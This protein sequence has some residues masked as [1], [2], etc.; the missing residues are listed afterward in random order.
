M[1]L[2]RAT[3]I[4]FLLVSLGGSCRSGTPDSE[5]PAVAP[6]RA[7]ANTASSAASAT[8][9]ERLARDTPGTT[10]AGN[11][12]IAPAG[13]SIAIRGPATIL[14]PLEANS[15]IAIIDLQAPSAAITP[16]RTLRTS[17]VTRPRR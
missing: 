7:P 16:G 8:K 4:A 1:F 2:V 11:R 3:I 6:D 15:A 9:A 5:N 13:W 12:F 10:A 14:E 17:T